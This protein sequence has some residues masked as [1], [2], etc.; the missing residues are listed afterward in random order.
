VKPFNGSA[1]QTA[2]KGVQSFNLLRSF[3]GIHGT[4]KLD[5][6]KLLLSE[7]PRPTG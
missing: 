7:T 5:L 1:Q 3:K 6:I 2:E 4:E